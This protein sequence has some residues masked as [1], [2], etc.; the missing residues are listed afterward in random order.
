M[1]QRG[2]EISKAQR[3][4]QDGFVS[5]KTPTTTIPAHAEPLT[6]H[7]LISNRQHTL[8]QAQEA[9]RGDRM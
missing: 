8:N 3:I 4:A 5:G 9:V 7:Q 1:N 2:I 6:D